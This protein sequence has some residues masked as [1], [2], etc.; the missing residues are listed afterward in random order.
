MSEIHANSSVLSAIQAMVKPNPTP[1]HDPEGSFD[2][3]SVSDTN[4]YHLTESK[5]DND[6]LPQDR[7]K[8]TLFI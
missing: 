1:V 2:D 6:T 4:E 8:S 7:R 5:N 3:N